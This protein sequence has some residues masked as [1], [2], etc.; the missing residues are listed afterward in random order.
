M[1]AIADDP[2]LRQTGDEDL[3]GHCVAERRVLVTR[4]YSTVRPL[5]AARVRR[6]EEMWGVI[7]LSR[8]LGRRG[9]SAGVIEALDAF[10]R[11][12]P[13]ADAL[14]GREAWV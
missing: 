2:S 12:H 3:L 8:R 9:A 10:L 14:V 13:D 4:D 6:G 1:L 7:F 11:A 5:A